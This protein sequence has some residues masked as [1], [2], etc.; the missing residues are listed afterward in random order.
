MNKEQLNNWN[1]AVSEHMNALDR[2][3]EDRSLLKRV[4][5]EHLRQFF[6]EWGK[7][8]FNRDFSVITLE[9]YEMVIDPEKLADLNMQFS[10]EPYGDYCFN[11][12][13]YPFGVPEEES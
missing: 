12:R 4:M 11:I 2:L 6:P 7:I 8:E 5:E 13:I 3:I 9:F 1:S 10:I